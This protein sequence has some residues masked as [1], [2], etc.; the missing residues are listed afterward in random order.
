MTTL[1]QTLSRISLV[2]AVLLYA[3]AVE[4]LS[5]GNHPALAFGLGNIAFGLG[6]LGFVDFGNRK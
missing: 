1:G 5:L 2:F 4:A 6:L 3:Q